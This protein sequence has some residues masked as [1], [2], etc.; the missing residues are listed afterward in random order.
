MSTGSDQAHPRYNI[1]NERE[2]LIGGVVGHYGLKRRDGHETFEMGFVQEL[3]MVA[4]R[5]WRPRV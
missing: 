4:N 2:L 3:Q 5:T 1:V